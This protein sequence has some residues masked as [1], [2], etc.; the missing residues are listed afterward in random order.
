MKCVYCQN[1][2]FSQ[3]D[4]GEEISVDRLASIMLGLQSRGC[5]N[6]NLVTPTHYLTQI[7]SSLEI[8][9]S[10]G[11]SIPIIYN[12]SGY[13]LAGIIKLLDG[14][15]DVYLPDMRYSDDRSAKEY[16]DAAEYVKFN[17]SAVAEMHR[18]AGDLKTDVNGTAVKGMIIRLLAIPN[19][20]S[21][22]VN[23][24]RFIRDN[25]SPSTYLSIMS[26]YY[27]TFKASEFDDISGVISK[28][29]YANIIDESHRLGLNN[30]WVQDEPDAAC[31]DL[32][33]TNI[34]PIER[35][36]EI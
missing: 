15:V 7:L 13:E 30:G 6:I 21:G 32:L 33:G 36:G 4:K 11:L 8:A 1:Y 34:K 27:P 10:K 22:T 25:L 17:R 26:Q 18:Q 35:T 5:H 29:E 28:Q 31:P 12:T 16:S 23:T 20:K 9:V 24:M 2:C 3:L 14:I 19:D